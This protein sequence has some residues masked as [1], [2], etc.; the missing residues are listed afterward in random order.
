MVLEKPEKFALDKI[1]IATNSIPTNVITIG[2][3]C[4]IVKKPTEGFKYE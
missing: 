1:N 2:N 4:K 3:S